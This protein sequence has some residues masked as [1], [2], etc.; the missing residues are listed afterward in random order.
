MNRDK[1]FCEI[2]Y[3]GTLLFVSENGLIIGKLQKKPRKFLVSFN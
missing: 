2:L 1:K 3:D